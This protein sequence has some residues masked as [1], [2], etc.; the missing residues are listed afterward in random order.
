MFLKY[1]GTSDTMQMVH[2]KL[3]III[4]III[5]NI[6]WPLQ[7]SAF[8]YLRPADNAVIFHLRRCHSSG[9]KFTKDDLDGVSKSGLVYHR[10]VEAFKFG[11]SMKTYFGD[12]DF[13]DL[14]E[15]WDDK[16]WI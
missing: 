3:T 16:K 8:S 1:L 2:Y 9:F 11:Y 14:S 4:I 12:E 5:I 15:V 10:M 13:T 7:C 6:Y